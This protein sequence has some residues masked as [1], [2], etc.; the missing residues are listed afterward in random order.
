MRLST[1][2]Q[3][4]DDYIGYHF[5]QS[6][7]ELLAPIGDN[8]VGES[9]RHNGVY[10]NIKEARQADDPTLPLGVWTHDLKTADWHLVKQLALNALAQKSK[11]LQLGVWLFE[12][13]IHIHGFAGIAPAALLIQELCEQYWPTMHPEMV[14]GDVEYRT[15][16]INWMNDKLTP[17]LG[18]LSITRAQLDGNDFS[19]NDWETA[20]RYDQL[21]SKQQIDVNKWEGATPQA[22]KQRLG[23]TSSDNLLTVVWELEDGLSALS[24]L[25]DWMDDHCGTESPSLM[26]MTGLIGRIYDML[27]NELQRR[28]VSLISSD[29]QLLLAAD[30]GEGGEGDGI[31]DGEGGGEGNNSGGSGG[32]SGNGPI[33]D[34]NDAFICLR[35]AAEF[36]MN[37]DPHSPVPYLVYTACDWGEKTAPDLYQE[38]FLLKGG[39]LNIFE[40]MGLNTEDKR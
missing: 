6:L 14:D 29:E 3:S 23:A 21:K 8:E 39:Q 28:G 11:D 20:Q 32:G 16:P 27:G 19:W 36:L 34:R 9:V 35:K 38:L 26:D 37:D 10:F 17:I 22:F 24:Q 2:E 33:R 25:Q 30:G 40:M 13:N 15:N 31:D 4:A 5:G 1:A 7:T 18:M 12:A